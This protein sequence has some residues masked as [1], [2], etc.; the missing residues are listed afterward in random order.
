MP[1]P[2]RT[3][4]WCMTSSCPAEFSIGD[5]CWFSTDYYGSCPCFSHLRS[6]WTACQFKPIELSCSFHF[7]FYIPNSLRYP[8]LWMCFCCL[9]LELSAVFLGPQDS[10]CSSMSSNKP[11]RPSQYFRLRWN[12]PLI[13][14]YEIY[15]S[16]LVFPLGYSRKQQAAQWGRDLSP[17]GEDYENV[18]KCWRE[19]P[20]F[21]DPDLRRKDWMGTS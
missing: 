11:L 7:H 16:S 15:F 20:S 8:K 12:Y 3:D 19:T 5:I 10:V 21:W 17:A 9:T 2:H 1:F 4:W 13:T 14:N 18:R 6:S